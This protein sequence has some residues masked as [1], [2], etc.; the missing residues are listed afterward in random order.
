MVLSVKCMALI[1]Y[2]AYT[3]VLMPDYLCYLFYY[4]SYIIREG[5][6]T[7]YAKQPDGLPYY[8]VYFL[9]YDT[10]QDTM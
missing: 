8:L 10:F 4:I 9:G 6:Q 2:H 5:L 7:K 3:Y 1:V